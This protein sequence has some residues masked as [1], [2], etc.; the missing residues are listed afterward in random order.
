MSVLFT[1]DDI[2]KLWRKRFE[3]KEIKIMVEGGG[4]I[5]LECDGTYL[6]D[7]TVSLKVKPDLAIGAAKNL[8]LQSGYKL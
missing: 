3:V 1:R 4:S 5:I 7:G 6:T 8:I 2:E